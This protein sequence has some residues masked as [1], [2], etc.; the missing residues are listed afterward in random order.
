MKMKY[1]LGLA[2]CLIQIIAAIWVNYYFQHVL[3]K[4][5]WALEP[6]FI[7]SWIAAIIGCSVSCVFLAL[8]IHSEG[9]TLP[10]SKK[11]D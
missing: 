4:E 2:F 11:V 6:I 1:I 8:L 9:A 10:S 3:G 5:H 7:T